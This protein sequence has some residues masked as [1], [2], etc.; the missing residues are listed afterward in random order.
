MKYLIVAL[1]MMVFAILFAGCGGESAAQPVVKV[2]KT[3]DIT[4]MVKSGTPNQLTGNLN[5]L[6]LRISSCSGENFFY[7]PVI[8]PVSSLGDFPIRRIINLEVPEGT[9]ALRIDAECP[10]GVRN[11]FTGVAFAVTSESPETFARTVEMEYWEAP[12]VGN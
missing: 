8:V 2:T 3:F 9:R 10:L 5:K 7:G 12:I 6:E 1:T 4:M 11:T